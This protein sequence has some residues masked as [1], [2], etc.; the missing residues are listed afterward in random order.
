MANDGDQVALTAGFDLQNA[1]PVL[2]VVEGDTLDQTG[3]SF[4]TGLFV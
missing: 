1:K 2:F 3:Q 4:R